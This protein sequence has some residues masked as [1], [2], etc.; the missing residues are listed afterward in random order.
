MGLRLMELPV[1]IF[2]NLVTTREAL[3]TPYKP[4]SVSMFCRLIKPMGLNFIY[5]KNHVS[6]SLRLYRPYRA[7]APQSVA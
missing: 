6:A 4:F 3:I 1:L 5:L 2:H 7:A